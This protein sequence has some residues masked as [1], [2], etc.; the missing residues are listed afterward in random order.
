MKSIE[1]KVSTPRKNSESK[2]DQR[3][4]DILRRIRV[5]CIKNN[6]DSIGIINVQF[7]RILVDTHI[8]TSPT[9]LQRFNQKDDYER[10]QP[11]D[12]EGNGDVDT[13]FP[14]TPKSNKQLEEGSKKSIEYDMVMV[15]NKTMNENENQYEIEGEI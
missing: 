4:A 1:N 12:L 2:D 9:D 13:N 8:I 7:E 11:L 10:I 6:C 15:V 3:Y 14:T 5:N